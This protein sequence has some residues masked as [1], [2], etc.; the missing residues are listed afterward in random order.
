MSSQKLGGK[1]KVLSHSEQSCPRLL[2]HTRSLCNWHWALKSPAWLSHIIS[3]LSLTMAWA[4][5]KACRIWPSA[6]S[7]NSSPAT[8]CGQSNRSHCR[9]LLVPWTQLGKTAFAHALPSA[10]ILV[11]CPHPHPPIR[12][13]LTH[14]MVLAQVRFPQRR[15][16]WHFT[17]PLCFHGSPLMH[18]SNVTMHSC[19]LCWAPSFSIYIRRMKTATLSAFVPAASSLSGMWWRLSMKEWRKEWSEVNLT[20][21]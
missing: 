12:W 21:N 11:S 6:A 15:L 13:K 20:D 14:L 19:K 4:S 16:S 17:P 7:P 1:G 5:T 9:L 3:Q 10:W 8:S 2:R 18:K